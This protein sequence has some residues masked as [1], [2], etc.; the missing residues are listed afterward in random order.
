MAFQC[1]HCGYRNTDIKTGGDIP[2]KGLRYTLKVTGDNPDDMKRGLLKSASSRIFIPELELEVVEGSLGGFYST[3]EG[4]LQKLSTQLSESNPFAVGDSDH[5]S[6]NKHGKM[7][8][9]VRKLDEFRLGKHPFTLILE[10]PMAG[11]FIGP[12]DAMLSNE[13]STMEDPAVTKEEFERSW[14]DDETLGLH[15]MKTENYQKD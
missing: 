7:G 9:I 1:E 4:L 3:T 14:E 6:T 2:A 13:I 10:D 8:E 5:Y 12:T 15:D 11:S